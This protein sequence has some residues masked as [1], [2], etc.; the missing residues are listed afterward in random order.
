ME[1]TAEINNGASPGRAVTGGSR[2]RAER[3]RWNVRC[4]PPGFEANV[5]DWLNRSVVT[6]NCR[7]N[8]LHAHALRTG[9]PFLITA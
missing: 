6:R 5:T 8:N 4:G 2:S 7:K 3:E 1:T 9:N